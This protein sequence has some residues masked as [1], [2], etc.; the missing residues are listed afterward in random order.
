M[1][2]LDPFIWLWFEMIST[3]L[4]NHKVVIHEKELVT[5]GFGCGSAGS[6][7]KGF[8]AAAVKEPVG[9]V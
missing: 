7:V 3:K 1:T 4:L 6:R 9:A 8:A 5:H 2:H